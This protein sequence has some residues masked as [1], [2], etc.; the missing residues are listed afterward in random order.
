MAKYSTGN[1]SPNT[2]DSCQICGATDVP[3]EEI[4]IGESTTSVCEDCNPQTDTNQTNTET[5]TDSKL[6]NQPN[7]TDT[8]P[9]YTISNRSKGN[10]DW[11]ENANYG[12]ADTPYMQKNYNTKFRHALKEHNITIEQLAEDTEIPLEDLKAIKQGNALNHGVSQD[13]IEVIE[14]TLDIK[15]KE[16][17]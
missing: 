15:L 8:T 13:A 16:D 9:G 14:K 4:K 10:P 1:S 7:D 2:D 6:P 12:N 5:H 17:I 3:L 11:I